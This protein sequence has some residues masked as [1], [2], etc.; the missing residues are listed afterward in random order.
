MDRSLG[1]YRDLLGMGVLLDTEMQGEM[2]DNEVGLEGAR[3]RVVELGIEA[4]FDHAT[5]ANQHR[6]FFDNRGVKQGDDI[7]VGANLICQRL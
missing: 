5:I 2:L 6:R 4:C 3:V 1:F 7:G